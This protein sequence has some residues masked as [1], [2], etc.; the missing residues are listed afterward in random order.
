MRT[1][2]V[3][4]AVRAALRNNH[5]E[6]A[7]GGTRPTEGNVQLGVKHVFEIDENAGAGDLKLSERELALIDAAFPRGPKPRVLPTL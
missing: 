1:V 7:V 5:R 6:Q 4:Q 2:A 3:E